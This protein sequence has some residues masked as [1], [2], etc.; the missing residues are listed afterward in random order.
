MRNRSVVAET[1]I[2]AMVVSAGR[3][4]D[5][6]ELSAVWSHFEDIIRY[7]SGEDVRLTCHAVIFISLTHTDTDLALRFMETAGL[8]RRPMIRV[9]AVGVEEEA[10]KALLHPSLRN[11]VHAHFLALQHVHSVSMEQKKGKEMLGESGSV[12]AVFVLWRG[13][14]SCCLQDTRSGQPIGTAFSVIR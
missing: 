9:L 4:G 3:E 6:K 11:T 14:G 10:R 1:E 13:R 2:G 8:W 5:H 12:R 7:P